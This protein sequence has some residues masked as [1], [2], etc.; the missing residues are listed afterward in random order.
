[1]P[2]F[3]FEKFPETEPIADHLDEIGRRGHGDRPHLR[4]IA[5]EGAARRWRPASRVWTRSR[6]RGSTDHDGRRMR[7]GGA[8]AADARPAAG[9]R[10]GFPRSASA[11]Q[12][13]QRACHYDP[14]FL[15]QIRRSSRPRSEVRRDGL[16]DDRA[17]LLELK[18]MG[19][20]DARLARLTRPPARPR[21]AARRDA[22][23]VHPVFKR[24]DTCAAEFE[25]RTPYLYS[26][27]ETGARRR[28]ERGMRG[29]RRASGAR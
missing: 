9:D 4:G 2:R 12:E 20:S 16:P 5:A 23:G 3:T 17:G 7:A 18:A 15:E 26:C 1:M 11:S 25:A 22:L 21:S 29:D 14:W 28:C 19:F 13:I 8:G 6:S 24:I 27:Y 10:P